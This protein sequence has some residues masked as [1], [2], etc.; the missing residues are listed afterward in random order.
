[1]KYALRNF[2]LTFLISLII[3]GAIAWVIVGALKN[4]SEEILTGE[5][6]VGSQ[7]SHDAS[8]DNNP[9]TPENANEKE[10]KGK[11][12]TFLAVALDKM[13]MSEKELEKWRNNSANDGKSEPF[14]SVEALML[15]RVDKENKRFVFLPLPTDFVINFKGENMPL[16]S[17]TKRANITEKD[18]I[19]ILLNEVTSLTGLT[20]D[21]H[22]VIDMESFIEAVDNIGGFSYTVPCEMKYED[23]EKGLKINFKKGQKL[24]KASDFLKAMQFVTYN[25]IET[26]NEKMTDFD[27]LRSKDEAKRNSVHIDFVNM[28]LEKMLTDDNMVSVAIWIP[29]IFKSTLT[30]FGLDAV[31]E[32]IDLIFSYKDYAKERITYSS[33]YVNYVTVKYSDS[34]PNKDNIKVAIAQISA[35]LNKAS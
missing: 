30:N 7:P 24:T 26:E 19:N 4:M 33:G 21:Y 32:N 31:K 15:I 2:G 18:N 16:G 12:F 20:I 25:K 29:E 9:N 10:F 14:S 13:P 5:V 3:F 22:A 11:S 1:M 27:L 17:I 35:E 34:E 23:P 6:A 28:V 8:V